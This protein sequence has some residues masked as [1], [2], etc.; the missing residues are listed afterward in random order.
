MGGGACNIVVVTGGCSTLG[1]RGVYFLHQF[2][3]FSIDKHPFVLSMQVIC[4][5]SPSIGNF[6]RFGLLMMDN[7]TNAMIRK[8]NPIKNIKSRLS[9]IASGNLNLVSRRSHISPLPQST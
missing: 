6:T 7:P 5:V 4:L 3:G 1:G 2:N 8:M 9:H